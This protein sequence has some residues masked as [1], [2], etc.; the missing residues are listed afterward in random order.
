MMSMLSWRSLRNSAHAIAAMPSPTRSVGLAQ[1]AG[2][3]SACARIAEP[4][5]FLEPMAGGG[6]E[7]V[8]HRRRLEGG[9]QL[10]RRTLRDDLAEV[11]DR[12]ARA[13]ALGLLHQVCRHDERRPGLLAQDRQP[14]PHELPR[15]RVEA[16]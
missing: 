12:E 10:R 9:A 1:A 16:D 5:S 15:R 14:L 2:E 6:R 13:V 11:H 7:D 3:P 8:L 4:T